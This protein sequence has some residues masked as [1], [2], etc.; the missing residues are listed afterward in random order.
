[1]KICHIV[2]EL[3][4]GG[5]EK[6]IVQIVSNISGHTHEVWCLK[7]KGVLAGQIEE[8]GIVVREFGFG[9]SI[10]SA[11]TF[12]LKNEL[13]RSKF[14][15]VHSHGI[16]PYMWAQVA[17]TFAGVPVHIAHVQNTYMGLSFKNRIRLKLLST[18]TSKFIAVSQAVKN[19]LIKELN[20]PSGKI[21]VIYNSSPDLK[22]GLGMSR[23][24]VRS[25]LGIKPDEFL[26]GSVGR[27]ERFKGH[28]ILLEAIDRCRKASL[29]CKCILVGD[30]PVRMALE[31][32][33]EKLGL[34]GCVIF[35]GW[36][37]SIAE[38]MS[39]M[40]VVIQ[41]S[42]SGEGLPLV[43]AEAAS[44]SIPLIATNVAGNNEIVQDGLSGFIVNPGDSHDLFHK[45]EYLYNRPSETAQMGKASRDIWARNFRTEFMAD[46]IDALYNGFSV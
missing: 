22:N 7:K 5:L 37:N 15:I 26:T 45:I 10:L 1:M 39:A 34:S 11:S 4:V 38:Y 32:Q 40:D 41:P 20:I 43:L 14:D 12:V 30:G 13:K 33:V 29:K 8:R 23:D 9:E 36:K 3:R 18:F 21:T 44:L 28:H 46:K 27:L 25:S 17:A 24:S 35:A 2:D 31:R 16:Y 6:T 42:I 19:N